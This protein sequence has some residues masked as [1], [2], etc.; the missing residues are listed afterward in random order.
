MSKLTFLA[1]TALLSSAIPAQNPY[2]GWRNGP[3]ADPGYF[4]L[5]VWLQSPANAARYKAAGINLFVGLWRGPT[6]VQLAEL[7]KAGMQVICHQNAAGLAHIDDP[8][9]AGWMHGDE[10]DNAQPVTDAS[11][12]QSYGPFIPPQRI[13]DDYQALVKK[14][15][16][17]PILLNLGQGVANDEWVG[18]GPGAKLSDYEEYVKGADIISFDVYPVAGIDK[19]NGEDYLWYVA[20]GLDRLVKW[21]GGKKP[22]W[23]CIET[24][25]ISGAK[26]ATP[27]Q[28]KAQVWMSLI[29][30]SRGIIYFVHEFAPRFNER[31]L[32]DDP[33][34]LAAV[35]A[36]N[37]QIKELA[38][39]LNSPTLPK[40][41]AVTVTP[42]S[43]PVDLMVKQ[44]GGDTY[45]F[46]VGMRNKPASASFA[47]ITPTKN[48]VVEVL[49]ENRW[50]RLND[51]RFTDQFRPYEVHLYRIH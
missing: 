24:T 29:H 35:T 17:R 4:P 50:L 32:L 5:A 36:L 8:T 20:N 15:P 25:R 46:A 47:V 21:T 45:V 38:P 48:R 10:P 14:D 39:V 11:G 9:I 22:I 2:A 31:R 33:E 13:I 23:N 7:K 3:P 44:H 37:R 12:R 51:G 16:S 42:D 41:V 19:P 1:L 6:E 49:G 43:A 26:A 28:I 40:T 18:R 34:R 27:E 30:G